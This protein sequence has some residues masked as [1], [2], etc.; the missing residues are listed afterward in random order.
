[1]VLL[2]SL[3]IQAL[4]KLRAYS[5]CDDAKDRLVISKGTMH[6]EKR[7]REGGELFGKRSRRPFMGRYPAHRAVLPECT[8]SITA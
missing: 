7:M 1:M 3:Q 5:H 4:D 6:V 2:L 8:L